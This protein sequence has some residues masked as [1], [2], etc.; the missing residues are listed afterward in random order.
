MHVEEMWNFKKQMR[1][2]VLSSYK[3]DKK[4]LY[5][6][7]HNLRFK[8]LVKGLHFHQYIYLNAP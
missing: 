5:D 8:E 2:E 4:K 7:E 1:L 6:K 3:E